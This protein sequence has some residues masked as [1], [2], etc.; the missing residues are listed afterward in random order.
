MQI[1]LSLHKKYTEKDL[2]MKT[3][4]LLTLIASVLMVACGKQI[5]LNSGAE[6][7]NQTAA[8]IIHF[9]LPKGYQPDFAVTYN[10]FSLAAYSTQNTYGHLYFIQ[11][12]EEVDSERLE[13]EMKKRIS[14]TSNAQ[15]QFHTIETLPVI[16][17]GQ[18]TT[19]NISEGFNGEGLDYKQA[20]IT[21]QGKSGPA[22]LVLSNLSEEWDENSLASLIESLHRQEK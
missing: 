21:F 3:R 8:E 17:D 18:E 2:K 19:L 13:Q 20:M 12:Q 22:L 10:G 5:T 16:V 6:E 11:S 1:H 14:E 9:E 4:I 15:N 7:V